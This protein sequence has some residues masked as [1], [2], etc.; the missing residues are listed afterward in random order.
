MTYVLVIATLIFS[1][2]L[3]IK[4]K[5]DEKDQYTD[6]ERYD[7]DPNW[8]IK[9]VILVV[10]MLISGSYFLFFDKGDRMTDILICLVFAFLIATMITDIIYDT[11][12]YIYVRG[13][14]IVV[15]GQTIDRKEIKGYTLNKIF[16]RGE[17]VTFNS[18][19]YRIYKNQIRKLSELSEKLHFQWKQL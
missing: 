5:R 8:V 16:P 11:N 14:K 9:H 4:L 15:S 7:V 19:K 13:N 6:Y 2:V 10:L 12:R 1:L 17:L 3:S 18:Q